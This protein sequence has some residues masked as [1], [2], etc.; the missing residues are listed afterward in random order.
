MAALVLRHRLS[1]QYG[2]SPTINKADIISRFTNRAADNGLRVDSCDDIDNGMA[3]IVVSHIVRSNDAKTQQ[4]RVQSLFP[5]TYKSCEHLTVPEYEALL[6]PT[7][8]TTLPVVEEPI[9]NEATTKTEEKFP[10]SDLENDPHELTDNASIA[11]PV[12]IS[13]PTVPNESTETPSKV[14]PNTEDAF[15]QGMMLAIHQQRCP[16]TTFEA[17]DELYFR[18]AAIAALTALQVIVPEIDSNAFLELKTKAQSEITRL[19]RLIAHVETCQ[20]C[21]PAHWCATYRSMPIE[22]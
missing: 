18:P 10:P 16:G 14:S 1:L 8:K 21:K 5:S 13:V 11:D 2:T 17:K 3:A 7:E 22:H 9:V 19:Q 12:E 15:I 4:T 20:E 6:K